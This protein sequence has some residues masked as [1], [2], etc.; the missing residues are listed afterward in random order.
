MILRSFKAATPNCT[1]QA[2]AWSQPSKLCYE[3]NRRTCKKCPR[4]SCKPRNQS[5]RMVK[6]SVPLEALAAQGLQLKQA[7]L[8]SF[9]SESLHT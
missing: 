8:E 5:D 7:E 2:A 6:S 4:G 1:S 3:Y 9:G